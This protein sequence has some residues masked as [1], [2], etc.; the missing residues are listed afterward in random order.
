M[1]LY[2]N[3]DASIG[4]FRR[5]STELILSIIPTQFEIVLIRELDAIGYQLSLLASKFSK[6]EKISILQVLVWD[7]LVPITKLID[8]LRFF[9]G[10]SILLVLKKL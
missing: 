5:Y 3:F 2:S 8:S 4:H 10:K 6:K 1:R 7:A 9:R